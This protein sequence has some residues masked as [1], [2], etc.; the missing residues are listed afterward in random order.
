MIH[1]GAYIDSQAWEVFG[2]KKGRPHQVFSYFCQD[3][4]DEW[5]LPKDG[6]WP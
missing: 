6:P 2:K 3:G 5:I 1:R 4:S